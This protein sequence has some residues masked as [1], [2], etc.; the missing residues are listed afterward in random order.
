MS[1][2]LIAN[3]CADLKPLEIKNKSE[4]K[5]QENLNLPVLSF[6]LKRKYNNTIL[7]TENSESIYNND[8]YQVK[9]KKIF[10]D[11]GLNHVFD[12]K[13]KKFHISVFGELNHF[14]ESE[15][16]VSNT[17][18]F[19]Y[20]DKFRYSKDYDLKNILN[21]CIKI[22]VGMSFLQKQNFAHTDLE[23]RNIFV[24]D[25]DNPN[26]T[27]LDTS[28]SI[29]LVGKNYYV[30]TKINPNIPMIY[31][32]PEYLECEYI[33]INSDVYSFGYIMYVMF[34]NGSEMCIENMID[35]LDFNDLIYK[36][37]KN[38]RPKLLKNPLPKYIEKNIFDL[39]C[40]CWDTSVFMR[41]LF[42]EVITKLNNIKKIL[43]QNNYM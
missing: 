8:S 29:D 39:I 2:E 30:I 35:F 22:A 4:E 9:R 7:N 3:L 31:L 25:D 33:S 12:Y 5:N 37:K 41:P 32:A 36:L 38:I 43:E 34:I 28:R 14:Y 15:N 1:L 10:I 26:I 21:L 42:S 13:I 27:I 11:E 18:L 40:Q 24:S 16:I 23:P 19:D 17:N 6:S 20:L